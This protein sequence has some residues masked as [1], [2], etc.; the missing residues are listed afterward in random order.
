[1]NDVLVKD[2]IERR[3]FTDHVQWIPFEIVSHPDLLYFRYCVMRFAFVPEYCVVHFFV[4]DPYN[5]DHIVLSTHKTLAEAMGIC[6][7][8][9]ACGGVEYE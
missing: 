4:E 2:N 1:M 5:M 8:L 6:R 7:V 9:L 3:V